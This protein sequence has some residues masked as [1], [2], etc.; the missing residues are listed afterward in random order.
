MVEL[1]TMSPSTTP[2]PSPSFLPS[3]SFMRSSGLFSTFG[4]DSGSPPRRVLLPEESGGKPP[5]LGCGSRRLPRGKTRLGRVYGALGVEHQ[6][7]PA[8]QFVDAAHQVA[9][10]SLQ[11][12]R[13][14]LELRLLGFEH[15]PYF[16]HQKADGA[17][18]GAHHDVHEQSGVGQPGHAEAP[19]QV[20]CHHDLSAQIDQTANH[21]RCQ[22]YSRNVL[23]SNHFLDLLDGYAQ[24][25]VLK[26][27]SAELLGVGHWMISLV[28][29]FG[30]EVSQAGLAGGF[31]RPGPPLP[32]PSP[33]L[34]PADRAHPECR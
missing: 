25:Q 13:R 34:R 20:D 30:F 6:Q 21:L 2:K 29:V 8:R 1:M 28:S 12:L 31:P 22:R 9:R 32:A 15:V 26:K 19:A 17:V 27:E 18:V 10:R 11:R 24:K 23:V 33:R 3:V 16:I 14:Q 5:N 7:E 4:P